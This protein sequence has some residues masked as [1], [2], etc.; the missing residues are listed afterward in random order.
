M[1]IFRWKL[2]LFPRGW[3]RQHNGWVDTIFLWQANIYLYVIFPNTHGEIQYLRD[4]LKANSCKHKI[5]WR[6]LWGGSSE[7]LQ[8]KFLENGRVRAAPLGKG[9]THRNHVHQLWGH[10][11]TW[12][13]H[14]ETWKLHFWPKEKLWQSLGVSVIVIVQ[15]SVRSDIRQRARVS[16]GGRRG[17]FLYVFAI[18]IFIDWP[19]TR[20]C[21]VFLHCVFS[22][23]SF[24]WIRGGEN[25]F[26]LVSQLAF[27]LI[28]LVLSILSCV[29]YCWSQTTHNCVYT[30]PHHPRLFAFLKYHNVDSLNCRRGRE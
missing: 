1:N 26:Y 16:G 15:P 11:N 6:R 29:F 24:N 20:L 22:N 7:M 13:C 4:G 12:S 25:A 3:H 19:R 28:G 2:T 14:L 27:S 21:L 5:C 17:C 30:R 10:V 9:S 8:I 23:V 18:S